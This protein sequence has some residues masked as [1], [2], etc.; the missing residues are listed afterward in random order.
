MWNLKYGM[1][2]GGF[3]GMMG[4][5]MMGNGM[6][7]GYSYNNSAD[8]LNISSEMIVSADEALEY[9]QN[10]LDTFE[11]GVTVSHEITAFY[12]YYTLDTEKDGEIVGMLSVN[13]FSGQV[14]PHTWHGTF[15]EMTEHGHD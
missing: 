4:G 9:A 7:G 10:Y 11:P 15:I 1:H 6:M 3:G 5:G 13:G 8:L 2:A 14:F 12:G